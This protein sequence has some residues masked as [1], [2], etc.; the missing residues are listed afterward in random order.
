MPAG[1]QRLRSGLLLGGL[2]AL[3]FLFPQSAISGVRDGLALWAGA[4]LPALLPFFVVTSLLQNCGIL[5]ALS[6]LALP[7]CRLFRLPAAAGGPLLA[8]WLSGAP[9]GAR[10]L[11][12]LMEGGVLSPSEAARFAAAATV[13]SPLFLVGTVGLYLGSPLLGGLVYGIHFLCALCNGLLWRGFGRQEAVSSARKSTCAPSA[14]IFDALPGALR[15][16]CLSLLF[17]GGAIAVFCALTAVLDTLGFPAALEKTLLFLLPADAVK[18]LLAGFFEVSNGCR[19]AAGT[20]LP[21]SLRMSMLCALS[22]FGGLSV[23]CQAQVF[24]DGRV[25]AGCYLLQRLT[26]AILSFCA[27]RGLFLCLGGALPAFSSQPVMA[28]LPMAHS[29][30]LPVLLLCLGYSLIPWKRMTE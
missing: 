22:A 26:H 8:G 28:A 13:T 25:K 10:L 15:S 18:P 6:P 29:Y 12:P 1:F 2:L 27:C 5:D 19:L 4:V 3:L 16:S 20:A 17:I 24:F 11:A 30:A 23:L 7:F 14:T 9:N 21:L